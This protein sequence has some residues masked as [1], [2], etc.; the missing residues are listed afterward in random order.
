MKK[1][2]ITPGITDLNRGDQALIWL[3]NDILKETGINAECTLLQSGNTPKDIYRQSIQSKEMGFEVISPV[4]L[5]PAR[6]KEDKDVSYTLFTK[7][8]WGVTG[9]L[10]MLKSALLLSKVPFFEKIGILFLGTEQRKSLEK[11]KKADLLIVKGGGFLHTYNRFSD[12][13][14]LYYSLYNLLLANKLSKKVIIM[15]NSFGPF[16][17]KLEKIIVKKVLNKCELIYARESI[18]KKYISDLLERDIELSPDLG[19]YIKEYSNENIIR[20]SIENPYS[21]KKVAITMRPYRFPEGGNGKEKY[22]RYIDEMYKTTRGLIDRGYHPIFVAH[23]LGPSAH[24]DDRIAIEEVIELLN[25]NN[26]SNSLYSY[27]NESNYNCFDITKLYSN[28]DYIIGTRFHSVIFAMTSL[29]PAIAISYSGNKTQGIMSDMGL[30]DYTVDIGS[31][32]SKNVLDK[33]DALVINESL[34][35][36]KIKTYLEDCSKDKEYLVTEIKK[37]LIK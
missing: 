16:I 28:M 22:K 9:I 26:I 6:G 23:T 10:D 17:G 29:I 32:D 20:N 34:V 2:L 27:I 15:P 30:E 13:Y 7:L 37:I 1:I 4:L 25:K 36:T 19:F 18:S 11:F 21:N 35:K 33:F 24:E 5:H 12:L 31:I 14:Y 3:I 8:R